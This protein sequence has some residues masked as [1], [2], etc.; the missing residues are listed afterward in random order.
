MRFLVDNQ[1]PDKLA[2][3]LRGQGHDCAHVLGLGLDTADDVTVRAHAS[4]HQQA[5]ISKDEDFVYL[6]LRPGDDGRLIWVRLRNCRNAVPPRPPP[7]SPP[8]S[9]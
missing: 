9:L 1:L 8:P 6:A 7:S 3:H 2:A 4:A 5:V